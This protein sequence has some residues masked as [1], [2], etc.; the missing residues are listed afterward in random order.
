MRQRAL[1]TAKYYKLEDLLQ[2]RLRNA[3]QQY[4]LLEQ[5]LLAIQPQLNIYGLHKKLQQLQYRIH[6]SISI[7]FNKYRQHLVSN[8]AQLETLSPLAT[9][10][11]GYSITKI[12]NTLNQRTLIKSINQV[13]LGNILKTRFID[14]EIIS[15]V[16]DIKSLK[17]K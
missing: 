8:V 16:L 11:R 5:R 2:M 15:K 14:G 10:I 4:T 1:L 12:D 3:T 13:Q 17:S 9:L 6:K 7:L